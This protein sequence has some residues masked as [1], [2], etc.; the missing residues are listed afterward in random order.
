[1]LMRLDSRISSKGLVCCAWCYIDSFRC[2]KISSPSMDSQPG[3][4][5]SS[6]VSATEISYQTKHSC[7]RQCTAYWQDASGDS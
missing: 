2:K 7:R 3:L 5:L 6:L 1:M 4:P